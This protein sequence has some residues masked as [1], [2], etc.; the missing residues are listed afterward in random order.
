MQAVKSKNTAPELMVRRLVHSMG[1]RFRLHRKDLPGKPD[2]VF[3]RLH[4]ALFVHGCF[5]HGH[6]CVRGSR[7]PVQNRAYWVDKIARNKERDVR[8][9]AELKAIGWSSFALW[10][11]QLKDV[12]A[13][14]DTLRRFLE[15]DAMSR[16]G[17]L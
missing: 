14:R 16:G 1:Y 8:V 2:L 5:W 15:S 11:C 17:P 9:R 7:V 3:P 6:N 12:D 13:A 4:K 10:E